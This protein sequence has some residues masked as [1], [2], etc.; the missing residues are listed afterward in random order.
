MSSVDVVRRYLAAFG[1]GDPDAVAACVTDDFVNEHL[2]ELGSGCA[3][4]DEYRRR[5]PGFL[6][7]F[8]GARYTIV[9]IGAL[10]RTDAVEAV[11]ARYRFEATY[12]GTPIDIPGVMWFEVRDDRVARRTDLWD[13]LTF[14]R[15]TGQAD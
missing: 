7:T 14:L 9:D 1:S 12:E 3:G 8:A 11:V 15:Q 4:R 5:L 10:D 6:S 2:S 13:S